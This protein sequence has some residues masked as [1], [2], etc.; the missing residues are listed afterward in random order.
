[1]PSERYALEVDGGCMEPDIHDGA[2]VMVDPA[3]APAVGDFVVYIHMRDGRRHLGRVT[4][5]DG[6]YLTVENNRGSRCI[7][8]ADMIT[9]VVG[10]TSCELCEA[11]QGVPGRPRTGERWALAPDTRG[12]G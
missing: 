7:M 10:C 8:M 4:A 6:V 5:F 11:P 2:I 1:M 9:G 3:A 12:E